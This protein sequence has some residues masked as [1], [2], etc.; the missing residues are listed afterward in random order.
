MMLNIPKRPVIIKNKDFQTLI[1]RV[2]FFYQE[3]ESDL[4]KLTL[5]PNM[6]MYM[7]NKYPTEEEFQTNRRK[8]YILNVSCN[9]SG[10]GTTMSLCFNLIIPD[11]EALGFDNLEEQFEFFS[12]MIYN[13]KIK[14]QEFNHFELD[15][16]KRNLQLS[17]ENGLKEL[18]V[19]H[20][21]RGL[22]L[23]DD[24]GILSRTV[25]NHRE[26]IDE[27][28]PNNLYEFY[29]KLIKRYKPAV[30]VFGNV[31]EK[32]INELADKYLYKYDKVLETIEKNYNHFL[33]VRDKVQVVEEKKGFKD[34]AVSLYYKIKDFREED[35]VYV[36]LIKSLL[37]SLSSRMLNKKLRDEH[38]FV[39]SSN[40]VA[41]S[42]YGVFE[43]AA[44]INKN[45]KDIVIEKI[46]EVM[47]EIKNPDN[48]S[49]YLENIK[50]RRRIGLIKRLDEKFALLSDEVVQVLEIDKCAKARYQ[51]VLK[52]SAE[53]LAKFAERF[54]LD[55]IYFVEEGEHE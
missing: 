27:V 55:T 8:K 18:R 43:I 25:E 21:V 10:V 35:F 5:L 46:K 44:Y 29:L 31:D 28:T 24:E 53:E 41:Y 3:Q 12:E 39:Y 32:R 9:K 47:D 7:N 50:E 30:F 45:N 38:D 15:R 40:V 37:T 26:Q 14:N 19:Y 36:N 17:I 20:S 22:E 13:P 42:R 34:S 23:V 11:V 1:V 52:I 33:K 54:V 4:A 51:E 49:E 6:L 16:E 2:M 48:I